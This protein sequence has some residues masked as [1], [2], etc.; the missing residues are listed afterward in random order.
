[1]EHMKHL[2]WHICE[3]RGTWIE[4]YNLYNFAYKNRLM[5][6]EPVFHGQYRNT[7]YITRHLP[8]GIAHI[9]LDTS[10]PA[11]HE[12]VVPVDVTKFYVV[13]YG[14]EAGI[15]TTWY[16]LYFLLI[17]CSVSN[18]FEAVG[19]KRVQGLREY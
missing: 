4:A 12:I 15:W 6:V 7:Q 2:G 19:S 18:D 5:F 17:F 9:P 10:Y 3:S 13:I 14:E 8:S 1:M 11:L 16:G